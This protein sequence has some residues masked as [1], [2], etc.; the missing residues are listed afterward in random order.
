MQLNGHI[1]GWT[2]VRSGVPQ[3]SVLRPL[4]FTIFIDDINEEVVC[5]ISKFGDD[6]KI[7]SQPSKCS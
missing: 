6:T 1:L 5:E 2:E 3:R 4:L 7:V